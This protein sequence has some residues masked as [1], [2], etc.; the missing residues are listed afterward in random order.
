[1]NRGKKWISLVLAMM[2]AFA[3]AA[4]A[5]AAGSPEEAPTTGGNNIVPKTD[6]DVEST[7]VSYTKVIKKIKKTTKK[8]VKVGPFKDE[9]GKPGNILFKKNSLKK[10][11]KMRTL[12]MKGTA[13]SFGRQAFAKC[14]RLTKIDLSECKTVKFGKK[15]FKG[16]SK[17]KLKKIKII[18]PK[19]M[20]TAEYKKLKKKLVKMGIKSKNIKRG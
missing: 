8:T 14:K 6:G 16:L 2:L 17:A 19:S 7:Q 9:N 13:V 12:K 18:L 4:D 5:L 1:M 10:L 15:A 3:V 20:S 11:K